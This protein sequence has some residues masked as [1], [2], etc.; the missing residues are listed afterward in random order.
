[1]T[2]QIARMAARTDISMDGFLMSVYEQTTRLPDG[3]RLKITWN[4]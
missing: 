2:S 4:A 1:M 3:G